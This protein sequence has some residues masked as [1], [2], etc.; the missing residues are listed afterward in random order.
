MGGKGL[1]SVTLENINR[2]IRCLIIT[3]IF[4]L[5]GI[6]RA[7]SQWASEGILLGT[8]P[9]TQ[10][11][12]AATSD[13]RGGAYFAYENDTSGD[14]DIFI[15]WID[16]SANPRWGA[17]GIP[18]VTSGGDQR[19]PAVRMNAQRKIFVAWQDELYL[20]INIYIQILDSSGTPIG[21]VGGM[22]VC[23]AAGEQ[24]QVKMVS[25]GADGMIL[26]WLDKRNGSQTDIYAQRIDSQGNF[27]WTTNGIPVTTAINNQSAH[28]LKSDGQGGVFV[29]WQDYRNGFSNTD[30]FAQR[31]N[32]M[33]ATLWTPN[34]VS[35]V[36]QTDNQY[37]PA[38]DTSCGNLIIAWDDTRG[39]MDDIYAQALDGTGSCLWNT[40]GVPVTQAD[41]TQNYTCIL[42]DGSGG[43]IVA[44]ADN[45]TGYDIYAQRLNA[46]GSTQWTVNGLAVNQSAGYQYIPK[47]IRDG[48]DGAFLVWNDN[49]D[50][51]LDLYAQHIDGNGLSLLP[52]EGIPLVTSAGNQQSQVLVPDGSGGVLC[53][54]E[55]N[56]DSRGDVYGQLVND[57]LSFQSPVSGEWWNGTV[58]DSILWQLRTTETL[59]AGFSI[60]ASLTPGD[61]YPLVISASVNPLQEFYAWTPETINSRT[62]RIQIRAHDSSDSVLC[63]FSSPVFSVDSD[64][65]FS[66]SLLEPSA[67]SLQPLTPTFQW[68]STTDNLSGLACYQLYVDDSLAQDSLLT[69]SYIQQSFEPL[70]PGSHTWT[71]Y[72]VDSAGV[73]RRASQIGSFTA[74]ADTTPPSS[75][76]L[77][78]PGHNTWTSQAKPRFSWE[79]SSDGGSGLE[80]YQFI[81][82]GQLVYDNILPTATSIDSILLTEG[83]HTW[84]LVAVDSCQNIR[85][86]EDTFVIRMDSSPPLPFS[87]LKPDHDSWTAEA[88]P[89]FI[90]QP[91]PDSAAGIGLMEYEIWVDNTLYIPSIPAQD[92]SFSLLPHQS[93]DEGPHTWMVIARDSLGNERQSQSCFTLKVDIQS[94]APFSLLSPSHQSLVTLNQPE[95]IWNASSDAVSGVSGYDVYLDG[96]PAETGWQQ[97]VYTPD[98]PL[99][100]GEHAWFVRALDMAGN[101]RSSDTFHVVI[102]TQPPHVFDLIS[103]D[104]HALLHIN[105][106][107]FIWRTTNDDV[108]GF[109]EFQ[110]YMDGRTIKDG[111]SAQDTC[112]TLPYPL[113]N[114]TYYWKVIAVDSA[115]LGRISDYR[116]FTI[117]C[118]PPQITSPDT[119]I[120][121]EDL[122]FTY[123]ATASDP[124]DD[125]VELTFHQIP[126]WLSVGGD[127][128]TGTP[129]EGTPDSAFWVTAFDGLFYDSLRVTLRVN[130]V[131]DAPALTCSPTATAT[132][133]VPFSYTATATDMEE[134]PLTFI[135]TEYPLWLTPRDSVLSGTPRE[136]DRDTSFTVIVSDGS[137]GDTL[138]V[139]LEVIPVND[140]PAITSADTVYA[141][142]DIPFSYTV[143]AE[144]PEED[145][146]LVVFLNIPSWLQSHNDTLSGT[147]TEGI[148]DT[149]FTVTVSDGFLSDTL[150]ATLLVTP[151]NDAPV[152]TSPDTLWA[153][154][155][156]RFTY[157]ANATDSDGPSLTLS[158][159]QIPAWMVASGPEITGIPENGQ[160]DT[161]FRVIASDT[162]L[163]D[164]LTVQVQVIPVNDPPYFKYALPRPV[165]NDLDTL[166][167]EISLNDYVTDPDHPDST[168][169]WSCASLDSPGVSVS[170]QPGSDTAV[171][172]GD[173]LE[174]EFH[175]QF[176][177]SDPLGASAADTLLIT[178]VKTGVGGIDDE[179][180]R[181]F[182]L[183]PNY[184]NPFNPSTTLRYALPKPVHITLCVY[185]TLGRE[186]V[187]LVDEKQ[188][189]GIYEIVW[190]ARDLSSGLYFCVIQ[191]GDWRQVRRM[192]L[193]K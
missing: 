141:I 137:L 188:E 33:G 150:Q 167:W 175:V 111:L 93:L 88:T 117:D 174:G 125:P 110:L 113:E 22:P 34:G 169:F 76:H 25:D 144:D 61:G 86:A 65:P 108:A 154:E 78:T 185:N 119:A 87:L 54:W 151:V 180:P 9:S 47:I 164:T 95:L 100:E 50:M 149:C 91:A 53:L 128:L 20:D 4:A 19:Y 123:V 14:R 165:F 38:A 58:Q 40:D 136:G 49:R 159:D 71:V 90:W 85:A 32:A 171:L 94:P 134:S 26:V 153:N 37:A 166:Y 16:G 44:W 8:A 107:R 13:N 156:E 17:Q 147:A 63:A 160:Q 129:T 142:E 162:F 75:F 92:T 179:I 21:P 77:I 98:P 177:V 35:V 132:E 101:T 152:I 103:P 84:T 70:S 64:P 72:A 148:R 67:G 74:S 112:F 183:S 120:A 105:Q 31:V 97:T 126:P 29:V 130:P 143:T 42:G 115:G 18:A 135:F 181:K 43:A 15:Q 168:L 45:R 122:P 124:E 184:P 139:S 114:G 80:K 161:C 173:H 51:N 96:Q 116:A 109:K 56:R 187:R 23:S 5:S 176:T 172:T 27:L 155:G 133:D 170:I 3:G 6:V 157:R 1:A 11:H 41:G 30:I 59:F 28:V 62:V 2:S 55:D 12:L 60:H 146:L 163:R 140:P 106:P 79:P 145:S 83:E 7:Q 131:N 118:N 189:P 82:D 36:S 191:A 178:L 69:T 52:S 182:D 190:N 186:V 24:S 10:V 48:A 99:S 138:Q 104:D 127:T 66:F 39:G 73:K 57:N 193:L 89:R 121:T 46:D 81:L 192:I 158:F 102:D 68:E